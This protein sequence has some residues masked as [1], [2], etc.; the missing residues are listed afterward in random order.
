M[1]RAS[2][3]NSIA[4][5]DEFISQVGTVK[6]ASDGTTPLSEPGSIGGETT[7]PVKKV[8]DRLEKVKEGERSAENTKDVKDL[9]GKPSIENAPEASTKAAS[10]FDVIGRYAAGQTKKAEGAVMTPGS[11]EDDVNQTGT[12]K[13]PTGEDPA[14]ETNSAKAGKEDP[15]SSH[16]ARTDNTALDG[17]KYAA[18]T[19]LEKLAA[20]MQVAG[21][22]LLAGIHAI[23]QGAPSGQQT[24]ARQPVKQAAA[25]AIDPQL[26]HQIGFELAGLVNG[27]W[28][29]QAADAFVHAKL[30]EV[31]KR[32]SDDADLFIQYASDYVKQ[33]E[34]EGEEN[35]PEGGG[36]ES[37]PPPA[38]GGGAPPAPGGGGGEEAAMMAALGGGAGGAEGGG[39]PPPD[40]GMGGGMGG[41]GGDVDPEALELAQILSSLGVTEEELQQAMAEQAAGGGGAPPPGAGGGMGA[42]PPGG[43]MG[44]PP[45]G[46]GGGGMEVQAGDRG[47]GGSVK[48]AA[49]SEYIQEIVSRS[50]MR[51]K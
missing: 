7:H 51:R 15:G 30:T 45:P 3:H 14:V 12:K 10:I 35:P 31:V 9:V 50:R 42:P 18:D 26:A 13:A 40:G 19:P 2:A 33:A 36:A 29:K 32:G 16:P 17:H 38:E 4:T 5:I 11:A 20:D 27:T 47:R 34:G 43:G 48:A 6:A 22:N 1:T 44:G 49:M 24:Q 46:G 8:D 21:N 41:G 23:Y 25:P 39:A 28:D 37:A